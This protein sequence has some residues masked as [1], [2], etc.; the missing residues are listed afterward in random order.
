M[1]KILYILKIGVT[2]SIVSLNISSSACF[3]LVLSTRNLFIVCLNFFIITI[4]FVPVF[5]ADS[6]KLTPVLNT[7]LPVVPILLFKAVIGLNGIDLAEPMAR[8]FD[9]VTGRVLLDGL[10]SWETIL[11]LFFFILNNYT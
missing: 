10:A 5:I 9:V 3:F 4:Y 2:F 1:Y 8:L 6:S 11:E 7:S